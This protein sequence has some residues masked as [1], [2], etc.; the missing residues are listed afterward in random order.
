MV[1]SL[2]RV[3]DKVINWPTRSP[4]MCHLPL[5][6][7][8]SN[9]LPFW[10]CSNH[11]CLLAAHWTLTECVP[12]SNLCT[13]SPSAWVFFLWTIDA[14]F[15]PFLYVLL[16]C[17][18]LSEAFSAPLHGMATPVPRQIKPSESVKVCSESRSALSHLELEELEAL[19]RDGSWWAS[20]WCWFATW[21]C[22]WI[23]VSQWGW[24]L[25]EKSSSWLEG[26]EN[27]DRW[28]LEL[29]A[30]NFKVKG[31]DDTCGLRAVHMLGLELWEAELR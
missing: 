13:F 26:R 29:I 15:L 21:G 20:L 28:R 9:T 4:G 25:K 6:G 27:G 18:P 19:H 30:S 14:L 7:P 2:L 12:T 17:L 31:G 10:L 23:T 1:T 3:K 8:S 11:T 24:Q 16:K 22:M 5:P